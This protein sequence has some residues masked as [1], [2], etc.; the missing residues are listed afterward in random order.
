VQP[1]VLIA[2]VSAV[3]S[4]ISVL[5]TTY[6][7]RRVT[8]LQHRLEEQRDQRRQ[9]V[10]AEESFKRYREP[11]LWSAHSLQSRL[12]NILQQGFLGYL[13]RGDPDDQR[14][15]RDNTVYVLA[16]YLCWVEIIR[17][18]QRFLDLGEV[19]RTKRFFERLDATAAVIATDH[20]GPTFRLFRGQ[21]RAIG[22]L[23]L[24]RAEESAESRY[25][26]MGYA[27][28]CQRLELIDLIEFLDPNG[29][30]LASQH[31]SRIATADV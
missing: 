12:Y 5:F 21:Q 8:L 18:D 28:F 27:A 24:V 1:E 14:Y 20:W 2:V 30:R 26:A 9:E 25:E 7:A 4:L 31:R 3:V 11:L 29:E 19:E 15:A 23:M 13:R 22:E 10:L 6:S 17:R 16:E